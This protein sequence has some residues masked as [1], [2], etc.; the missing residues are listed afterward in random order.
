MEGEEEKEEEEE[1]EESVAIVAQ[2]C[3]AQATCLRTYSVCQSICLSICS[4][5]TLSSYVLLKERLKRCPDARTR[6]KKCYFRYG[7]QTSQYKHIFC[8]RI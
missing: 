2:V 1:E 6:S 3:L 8:I 7:L 5:F 4:S